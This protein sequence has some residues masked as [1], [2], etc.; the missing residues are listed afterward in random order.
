MQGGCVNNG[1]PQKLTF[2]ITPEEISGVTENELLRIAM[3]CYGA[4]HIKEDPRKVFELALSKTGP[5]L[6]TALRGATFVG[7]DG[8][9][10]IHSLIGFPLFDWWMSIKEKHE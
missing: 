8:W 5:Y 2:E 10:K 4:T 6:D 1:K 7:G 3:Y 9:R